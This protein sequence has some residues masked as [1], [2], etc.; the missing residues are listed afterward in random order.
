MASFVH[1]RSLRTTQQTTSLALTLT[2]QA[3]LTQALSVLMSSKTRSSI[4]YS[5][6]GTMKFIDWTAHFDRSFDSGDANNDLPIISGE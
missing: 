4:V 2:F 6:N 5:T 3:F 1:S